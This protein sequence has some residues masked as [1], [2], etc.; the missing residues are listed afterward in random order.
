MT[1]EAAAVKPR[2]RLFILEVPG[3]KF[4]E[5]TPQFNVHSSVCVAQQNLSTNL[6]H[7]PILFDRIQ[8][9]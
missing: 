8:P 1:K 5:V 9:A 2:V 3:L 6:D 7:L 4:D